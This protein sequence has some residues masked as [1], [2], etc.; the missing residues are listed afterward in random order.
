M[1]NEFLYNYRLILHK[2]AS[3]IRD[4]KEFTITWNKYLLNCFKNDTE[5]VQGIVK[6]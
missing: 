5:N 1:C 3:S 6:W 2:I 4:I